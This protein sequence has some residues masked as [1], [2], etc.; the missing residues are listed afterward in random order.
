M[1]F[2]L[3][4]DF[5]TK[6]KYVINQLTNSTT[7]MNHWT[8]ESAQGFLDNFWDS[9]I[10]KNR[11]SLILLCFFYRSDP[12]RSRGQHIKSLLKSITK[13]TEVQKNTSNSMDEKSRTRCPFFPRCSWN[14][15]SSDHRTHVHCLSV[16]LRWASAQRTKWHFC[17][18]L[19]NPF[20]E[21]CVSRYSRAQFVNWSQWHDS[22]SCGAF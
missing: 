19:I 10:I 7:E 9:Q 11:S 4:F 12:E 1:Q 18:E 2:S 22:L 8:T 17:A 13:S 5:M 6:R 14:M 15:D 21:N 3:Q 16:H 20:N